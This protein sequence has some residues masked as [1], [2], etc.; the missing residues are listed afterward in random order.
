MQELGEVKSEGDGMIYHDH[1]SC[2]GTEALL[3]SLPFGTALTPVMIPSTSPPSGT[4]ASYDNLTGKRYIY[5]LPH[6]TSP[7]KF[8]WFGQE[9]MCNKSEAE[10][11]G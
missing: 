1:P 9:R 7:R 11:A 8:G 4:W 6:K 5:E 3:E 10:V 2:Y